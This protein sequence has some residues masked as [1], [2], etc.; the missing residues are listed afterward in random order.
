MLLP[1]AQ[2]LQ[3]LFRELRDERK[4]VADLEAALAIGGGDEAA[5]ALLNPASSISVTPQQRIG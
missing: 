4:T 1:N 2:V 5:A 3:G